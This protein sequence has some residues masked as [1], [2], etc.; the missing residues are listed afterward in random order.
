MKPGASH[1]LPRQRLDREAPRQLGARQSAAMRPPSTTTAQS[2]PHRLAVEDVVGGDGMRG[3][4]HRVRVTLLQVARAVD[5]D[6]AQL[7]EPHRHAVEALH[8][9]DGVGL[10]A[11]RLERRQAA[12]RRRPGLGDEERRALVAQIGREPLAGPAPP[13]RSA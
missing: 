6:A 11:V 7:G 3:R 13:R 1:A 5:V 4:A 9:A 10:G 2:A 12:G 8:Q